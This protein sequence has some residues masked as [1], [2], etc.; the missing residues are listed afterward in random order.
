MDRLGCLKVFVEVGRR[1]SFSAAATSLG[2]SRAAVT[3]QV[4]ALERMLGVRLLNRTTNQVSLTEPGLA[5]LA[6]C[7]GLFDK[8]EELEAA[9]RGRNPG[10]T[11]MVHVGAPPSF[12]AHCMVPIIAAFSG[13]F[14]DIHVRLSVDSH[15]GKKLIEEG[16]DVLIRISPRL[17]DSSF[18]A[19]FLLETQQLLVASPDYLARFGMPENWQDLKRHNCLVHSLKSATGIWRATGP[20]GGVSLRVGGV[21]SSNFNEALLQST[22][23]G[24]GISVQPLYAIADEL[25][26]GCL[27]PVLQQYTL[28]SMRIFAVCPARTGL[29]SRVRTFIDFLKEWAANNTPIESGLDG[30]RSPAVVALAGSQHAK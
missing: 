21:I 16:L 13:R 3:K 5:V 7:Q 18:V 25:V 10:A 30:K 4:A 6:Q 2:L 11:G 15:R 9:A 26:Q 24:C 23:S 27:I 22:L 14:P 19:H 20:E 17:D 8:Y 29:P 1:Q 28:E 12:G